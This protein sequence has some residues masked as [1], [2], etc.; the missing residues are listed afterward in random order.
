M[1]KWTH[2]EQVISTQ[3]F[4]CMYIGSCLKE[5]DVMGISHGGVSVMWVVV[6]DISD[7]SIE[8]V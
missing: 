8:G 2:S 5:Y 6:Y 3:M 1:C 4:V 7:V